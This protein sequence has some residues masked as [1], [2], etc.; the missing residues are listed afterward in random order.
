[1][2]NERDALLSRHSTGV[3]QRL[4]VVTGSAFILLPRWYRPRPFRCRCARS[5]TRVFWARS[6]HRRSLDAS[7]VSLASLPGRRRCFWIPMWIIDSCRDRATHASCAIKAALR[8]VLAPLSW[9]AQ[10]PARA[11]GRGR[12]AAGLCSAAVAANATNGPPGG[13]ASGAVVEWGRAGDSAD[14]AGAGATDASSGSSKYV[15]ANTRLHDSAT[16]RI[17]LLISLRAV[18][19][20][21][22]PSEVPESDHITHGNTRVIAYLYD[23]LIAPAGPAMTN[24]E[25]LTGYAPGFGRFRRRMP[26]TTGSM[27]LNV[28]KTGHKLVPKGSLVDKKSFFSVTEDRIDRILPLPGFVRIL[29]LPLKVPTTPPLSLF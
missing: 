25:K 3:R 29:L 22:R 17:S 5:T 9:C 20:V 6:D 8:L 24:G 18:E 7:L 23:R 1:M 27:I 21:Q 2:A 10:L 12:A 14:P 4:Q 19:H 11:S 16:F 15:L 28:P 26:T 13:A